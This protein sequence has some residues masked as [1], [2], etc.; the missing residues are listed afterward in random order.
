MLGS[1]FC[2]NTWRMPWNETLSSPIID[3]LTEE[4]QRNG[5][6]AISTIHLMRFMGTLLTRSL[7]AS[8]HHGAE[9]LSAT[10]NMG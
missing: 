2:I 10:A 9:T 6:A 4:M 1:A 8:V 5:T 7:E 3:G